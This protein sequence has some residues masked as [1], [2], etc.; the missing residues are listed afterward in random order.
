MSTPVAQAATTAAKNAGF[1]TRLEQGPLRRYLGVDG[2]VLLRGGPFASLNATSPTFRKFNNALTLAPLWKWGLAIVPLM[3]VF[4]GTPSVENLDVNTSIA[5]ASTGAIWAYYSTL[6]RPKSVTQHTQRREPHSGGRG[7]GEETGEVLITGSAC[8]LMQCADLLCVLCVFP[9]LCRWV[10]CRLH[11]WAQTATMCGDDMSQ[12]HR[13]TDRQT[14]RSTLS[15]YAVSGSALTRLGFCCLLSV[16]CAVTS[17][18]RK[19][20]SFQLKLP[21][22]LQPQP[23]HSQIHTSRC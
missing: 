19:Q 3:G 16:A 22:P 18:R 9:G 17:R 21:P 13:Q 10:W 2:G 8:P 14:T 15:T 20:A 4:T 23:A 12:R 1:I 5:L 11:C 6:V 7:H